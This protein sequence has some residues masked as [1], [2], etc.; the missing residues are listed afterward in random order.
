[1]ENW[2]SVFL[3]AGTPTAVRDKLERALS[4]L[5]AQPDVKERF[6]T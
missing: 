6:A 3:P 2:Y 1:M 4:A 5:V